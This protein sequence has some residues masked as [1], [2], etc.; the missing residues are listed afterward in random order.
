MKVCFLVLEPDFAVQLAS[1]S[2]ARFSQHIRPI[3][4]LKFT[5]QRFDAAFAFDL[6]DES[7]IGPSLILIS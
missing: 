5:V 2:F 3:S 6:L 7:P 1:V 4:L